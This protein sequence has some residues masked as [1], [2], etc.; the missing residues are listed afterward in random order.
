MADLVLPDM[1]VPYDSSTVG[2]VEV[3]AGYNDFFKTTDL[4][5][6]PFSSCVL[7]NSDC[8]ATYSG[9]PAHFS[10]SSADPWKM[11]AVRNIPNGFSTTVCL[12]CI[13]SYTVI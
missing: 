1:V 6:C 3:T 13:A 2:L 11:F 9:D 5:N 8:V 12:E 7:K 4:I 10:F